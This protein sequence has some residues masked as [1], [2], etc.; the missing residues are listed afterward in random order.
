[1][2]PCSTCVKPDSRGDPLEVTSM[3]NR[4]HQSPSCVLK[5]SSSTSY[6]TMFESISKFRSISIFGI[7]KQGVPF[8]LN[9]L[10]SVCAVGIEW[11]LKCG[12]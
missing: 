2:R 8:N 10:S 6:I 12:N 4:E 3:C 9:P 11:L 5:H 1:M 7:W